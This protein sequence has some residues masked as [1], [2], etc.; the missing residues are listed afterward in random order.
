M[1]MSQSRSPLSSRAHSMHVQAYR[2]IGIIA[3]R[4]RIFY[5]SRISLD[6]D[7][8]EVDDILDRNIVCL[9]INQR[10]IE[11]HMF[12]HQSESH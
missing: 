12:L 9:C 11:D 5:S 1:S 10:T 3:R 7:Q 6:A 8:D 2:S 4:S